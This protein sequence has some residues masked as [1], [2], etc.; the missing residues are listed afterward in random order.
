[1]RKFISVLLALLVLST[2][3]LPASLLVFAAEPTASI[4]APS[5]IRAGDTIKI[6]FVVDGTDVFGLECNYQFD[7]KQVTLSGQPATSLSG[8]SID[9]NSSSKKIL[10]TDETQKNLL[11][12]KKTVFT[13]SF[14][15][16]S[17]LAVGT[18][19]TIKFSQIKIA[20]SDGG[21]IKEKS[22]SDITYTK[23]V[24]P[25]K[26]NNANLKSLTVTGCDLSTPFSSSKTSYNL[27]SEVPYSVST[28][29]VKAAAEDAN[30]TVSVSG[31]NLTVGSNTVKIT[32]T[33]ENGTTKKTY[34]ISVVRKQD[35]QY[36]SSDDA[37]LSSITPSAGTLSPAF[38]SATTTYIIYVPFEQTSFHA[39]ALATHAKATVKEISE[40]PLEVGSNEMI[41]QVTSESGNTT[42]YHL[43][44]Y[45][46]PVFEGTPPTIGEEPTDPVDNPQNGDN[47][48]DP[49][50]DTLPVIEPEPII[51]TE[52]ITEKIGVP[53]YLAIILGILGIGIGF[54]LAI[55]FIDKKI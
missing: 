38:T 49:D 46:L 41:I 31:K 8:W 9:S 23:T 37:T 44:I 15:A 40:I 35:P 33:A 55:A 34:S 36:Q 26:S 27:K 17:N 22:A 1:M 47:T 10:V 51:K 19:V 11:Q 32:V 6:S 24:M 7:E 42:D 3:L 4:S 43:Y 12:S 45:R 18:S 25:P 28:L 20:Y 21:G 39:T 30:A 29:D 48:D 14:K 50:E 53:F 54:T 52:Y 5:E 13:M 16:V 2:M